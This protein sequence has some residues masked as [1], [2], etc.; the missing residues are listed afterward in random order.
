MNL[1]YVIHIV[2]VC[3]MSV[4]TSSSPCGDEG[5][6]IIL[7]AFPGA[8]G[9][10]ACTPGGRGGKV[11][12]VTT[13]DDYL[14]GKE[15][16]IEGSLRA[17]VDTG[18]PR[19]ILFRLSGTIRLKD[20]LWINK[21]FVSI[22]GQSAPGDGICI[23]D[24]Q[25]VVATNDVV[26]RHLRIRSGG[27]TRVEQMAVG[28]FG[29][30][31]SIID[32]CSMS[33]ATDEV[34][35]SFGAR[36]ISVQ[37]SIIAEGLSKSFHPKGEHSKGSIIAGDGGITIHHCI[38]AHNSARN[39]RVHGVQLDF[40]N[41][42]VYNW[43]YR[44]GYTR[45]APCY[46][47]Y[48]GNYFKPGPST[49][50][51]Q[52]TNLFEPGDDTV[53][54]FW[55]GNDLEGYPDYSNDNRKMIR[56]PKPLNVEELIPI[57]L[58]AEAFSCPPV[59]TETADV[60]L[61]RVLE[62]CG[63]TL[64]R[65]D[66]IDAQLMDDIK[67]GTGK[68]IDSE[69]ELGGWPAL[70]TV[71]P[72][73]DADGDGMPDAWQEKYRLASGPNGDADT[74]GYTDL[75]EYLNGTDPL[76]PEKNSRVNEAAFREYQAQ[77]AERCAQGAR[78]YEKL[79]AKKK[80]QREERKKEIIASMEVSLKPGPAS[81]A[82]NI[83]LMQG[84]ETL[85]EL[86]RVNAGSF[87]MGS[88]DSEEGQ[89]KE[90]PQHKVNISKPFYMAATPTTVRQFRA[91]MGAETRAGDMPDDLPAK[92]TTWFEAIEFCEILTAATGTRFRLP[93]EAQWEYACRAGTTTAFYTG[94]TIDTDQANFNGLEASRYNP[95]GIFRGK[96]T[97]V[98]TF[99]PNPWGFYDM[100]GNQ[101][102]YCQDFA[103]RQYT[104]DEVTD[105][106]GT[107]DQGGRV[108]RG[109]KAGSKAWYIRS[110][111]RYAYA[112]QVGYGFRVTMEAKK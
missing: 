12:F 1:C 53:R 77:A 85:I 18:G 4:P 58:A 65:R 72:E 81:K 112:P 40:R 100:P 8:E 26:L 16:P 56:A 10:G 80:Q 103:Y 36:N 69:E 31:N 111:A 39:P 41:N 67:N 23:R 99:P 47:N 98:K 74:D 102:E 70:E 52:D 95:A 46:V 107:Q 30:R 15:P 91:I 66:E 5:M 78:Q 2:T 24:Y 101:A 13:L 106:I 6:T 110:A 55:T 20:D 63:A 42:V 68:I 21:P 32:H 90:R 11:L 71:V 54:M 17:A 34:M 93:T 82:A 86:V 38:Y 14:P 61:A 29:G 62:E 94:D 64:P 75:E 28:I 37:W 89:E 7:K 19:Y 79:L 105:P 50:E 27:A 45:E 73:P 44:C 96:E 3:M 84:E 104:A 33:W 25:I 49:K 51:K 35:T 87:L 83:A 22:A 9:Y 76:T 92:E 59:T 60:A 97:P 43:G 48:I 57:I 88:P 109:G 108:L